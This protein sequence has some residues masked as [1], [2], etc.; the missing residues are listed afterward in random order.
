MKWKNYQKLHLWILINCQA[1]QR[2][3]M[4]IGY[5]TLIRLAYH[6]AIFALMRYLW[7]HIADKKSTELI[8]Y[9]VEVHRAA[10][11]RILNRKY[12]EMFGE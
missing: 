6:S 11:R 2:R 1:K 7:N 9:Y 5:V 4:K 10:M 3:K 12:D 8:D